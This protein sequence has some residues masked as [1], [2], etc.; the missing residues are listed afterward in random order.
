MKD[1]K[2]LYQNLGYLFYS[3]AAA[4]KEVTREEADEVVKEVKKTWAKWEEHEDKY[5]T[6]VAHYITIAFEY[7]NETIPTADEAFAHFEGYYKANKDNFSEELKSRIMETA[8]G[9]AHAFSGINKAELTKLGQL[10]LLFN[11]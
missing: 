8:K 1:L 3:V 2:M 6:D 4:D 11:K 9:V 10:T 7:L 5:G